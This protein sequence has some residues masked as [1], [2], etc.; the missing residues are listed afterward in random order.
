[1]RWA[2]GRQTYRLFAQGAGWCG[3]T[4]YSGHSPSSAG[5]L[6]SPTRYGRDTL[7]NRCLPLSVLDVHG[8]GSV[9]V[10]LL[11]SSSHAQMFDEYPAARVTRLEREIYAED[12]SNG[13]G[14]HG[15]KYA[16][17]LVFTL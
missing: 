4:G 16:R 3:R 12:L 7:A 9:L 10:K 1:M 6:R 14:Q 2:M 5:S 15:A 8:L 17:P 11:T 13:K